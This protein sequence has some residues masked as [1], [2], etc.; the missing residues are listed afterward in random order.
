MMLVS[1]KH[2]VLTNEYNPH[3][4]CQSMQGLPRCSNTRSVPGQ[5]WHCAQGSEQGPVHCHSGLVV[6]FKLYSGIEYL[7]GVGVQSK[8]RDIRHKY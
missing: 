6:H 8:G 1:K 3:S 4:R 7:Y 5:C 2:N